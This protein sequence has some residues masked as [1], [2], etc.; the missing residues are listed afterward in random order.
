[1]KSQHAIIIVLLALVALLVTGIAA[2]QPCAG[3]PGDDTIVCNDYVSNDVDGLEGNDSI[4]INGEVEDDVHGNDGDDT[5]IVNGEVGDEV[6][7]GD[8]NDTLIVT[9]TGY[10]DDDLE[11]EDGDDT[12][13]NAGYVEDDLR[14][15]AGDDNI[16]VA[17][18][19][20]VDGDVFGGEDNDTIRIEGEVDGYVDGGDGDDNI[21]IIGSV[22]DGVKGKKGN[23]R[24]EIDMN[25]NWL[26]LYVDGGYDYVYVYDPI[27]DT[28]TYFEDSEAGITDTLVLRADECRLFRDM[29]MSLSPFEGEMEYNGTYLYWYDFEQLEV[30]LDGICANFEDGRVN[31]FDAF[32]SF[33]VYCD[34]AGVRVWETNGSEAFSVTRAQIDAALAA[35][36][37]QVIGEGMGNMLYVE[38]GTLFA[39]GPSIGGDK[40]YTFD[41]TPTCVANGQGSEA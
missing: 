11:G 38:N 4:T 29:V 8:G 18:T 15:E 34:A 33:A 35:G 36:S 27:T 26:E 22:D 24:I 7:G 12:L 25:G 10:V 9:V 3:T 31:A 32:A 28:Y 19:G 23:D 41:F 13:I 16:T 6:Y 39:V 1:M 2:A 37:R 14:G 20:Y 5:I 17:F 40:T 21:I 30:I